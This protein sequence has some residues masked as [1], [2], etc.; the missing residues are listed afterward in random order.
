MS[1]KPKFNSEIHSTFLETCYKN[2]E[3]GTDRK[4][5][6]VHTAYFISNVKS[7]SERRKL[8]FIGEDILHEFCRIFNRDIMN[9]ES[10]IFC[11]NVDTKGLGPHVLKLINPYSEEI[12]KIENDDAKFFYLTPMFSE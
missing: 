11:Y 7:E 9:G 8:I 10:I 2:P 1:E 6:W 3:D 4:E 5:W 12:T